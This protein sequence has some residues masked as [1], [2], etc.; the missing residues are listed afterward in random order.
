MPIIAL[1]GHNW[2][3]IADNF[4]PTRAPLSIKNR[5]SLLMRR[6]KRQN[7]RHQQRAMINSG[8]P[9][10]TTPPSNDHPPCNLDLIALHSSSS[11]G[12]SSSPFFSAGSDGTRSNHTVDISDLFS[13]N[14][15][16]DGAGLASSGS[17]SEHNVQ[18][19]AHSGWE[20]EHSICNSLDASALFGSGLNGNVDDGRR[21]GPP[22]GSG[23]SGLEF[24][25]TCSRARLKAM[26]CHVFEGAMSET[27]GLSEEEPV[28]VT[29][30]LKN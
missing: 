8:L 27:A 22:A 7:A 24:S 6:Q 10:L 26:V 20:D 19:A 13:T 4:L 25:V 5:Y 14:T 21:S 15:V 23:D 2:K 16:P 28:T 29:L 11:A 17:G 9:S 1:Y 3:H 12:S 18:D 30:R